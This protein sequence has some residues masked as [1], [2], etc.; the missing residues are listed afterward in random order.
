MSDCIETPRS[1]A[2]CLVYELEEEIVFG[3]LHP[4]ER[5]VEDDLMARFNAKRHVVREA[6]VLLETMGLVERRRNVGAFVRAFCAK[7]VL[8]LYGLRTLLEVEAAKQISLPVA[9]ERLSEL[10]RIQTL[11]DAAVET[12]N[13]QEVFRINLLFHR[14]LFGLSGNETLVRAIE[15][16]ARQTYAIRFAGLISDGYRRTAQHEHWQMIAAL[17]DGDLDQ[18]QLLCAQHLLPS[19]DAYLQAS[20]A[21]GC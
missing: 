11:H 12:G 15:E 6:L 20:Q 14:A 8:E 17:R 13:A 5:L 21:R 10:E 3:R 9:V 19:R 4:R 18:L 2:E 7:Q 1:A 16:Y